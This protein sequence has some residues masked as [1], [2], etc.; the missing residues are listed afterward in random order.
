MFL[1]VPGPEHIR[2]C[3]VKQGSGQHREVMDELTV[4]VGKP[5]EG[6]YVSLIF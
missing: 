4:E 5:Q 6:L 1:L 2:L 3:K